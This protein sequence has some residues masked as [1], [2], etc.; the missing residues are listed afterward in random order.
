MKQHLLEKASWK[1]LPFVLITL[2][3]FSCSESRDSSLLVVYE[4]NHALAASINQ[5]MSDAT[6]QGLKTDT[7]SL[8]SDRRGD[9]LWKNKGVLLL[10]NTNHLTPQ[11]QTDIE[12]YV[13]TG[14]ALLAPRDTVNQYQWPWLFAAEEAG[15]QNYDGGRVTFFATATD[16]TGEA[17]SSSLAE[18]AINKEGAKS[19]AAPDV[20]RFTK[21]ILDAE[22]NEPMELDILPDGK[23]L[24][25]E[26]EGN[27]KMFD[28]ESNET[29]ILHTFKVNTE[30]N[31]EDGMLGLA[32]D[33]NYDQNNWIYIYYSPLG[34]ASRQN[35]SRFTLLAD[36]LI[37]GSEKIVLE[38]GVQRETCCHSGGGIV[39]GPNGHL[40][41]STGDNTSSKESSG[42]SP[43]DERPGRGPF[44]SQ[45][46][47]SNTHD[48]RGKILRIKPTA[49]GSYTI[50]DGNLFPKD[51]SQGRPEIYVMGCRN[52]FRFTVDMKT[53]YVYWGDV[54]PD[55]GRD[56]EKGP[57][58]Y[59]EWNQ[60]KT[61][62]FYGWP[63]FEANNIAFPMVDFATDEI[64]PKQDPA[65][66]INE[67]PNN[68]GSRE[69]PPARP[70]MIW[71]PYGQSDIWP[72]LGTGSRS[73][74]SGPMYY[75][76]ANASKAGFPEY[77]NGKLFIY[78]WA[79]SW[80]KVV[81][82]DEDWNPTQIESF[83]PDETFVKPIDMEFDKNG[84]MYLLEYGSN[85]F[86]NNVD[87]R[88]VRIEYAE[89]N[90]APVP[91]VATDKTRGAVPLT[92]NF[93]AQGSFDYDKDDAL[94]FSWTTKDGKKYE[95]R[96]VSITFDQPGE[97]EVE[98]TVTDSKGETASAFAR[99]IAGNEPSNIDF[100]YSG[101]QSFYFGKE[102]NTYKVIVT[103][104]EDGS[105]EDGSIT[106][107]AVSVNFS[108]LE[109]G[110][111][112]ANLGEDFFKNP[113]INVK[114]KNMIAN[115]DCMSCHSVDQ[116]S[117]GPTYI[118][119][120]KRYADDPSSRDMLA[121]K[122][123]EGGNG[124]WGHSL[125][126][127][128]PQLT[129]DETRVMVDYILSLVKESPTTS[130]PLTSNITLNKQTAENQGAYV[131]GIRYTDKGNGTIP[132]IESSKMIM[133]KAPVLEAEN[134]NFFN[135]VQQQR[136]NGG[137]FAFLSNINDG[138]YI[139]YKNIDLKGISKIS[140]TMMGVKGGTIKVVSGSPTG[141]VIG[142]VDVP[143]FEGS[144]RD[145]QWANAD[146][147]IDMVDQ[148]GNLYF[149]VSHPDKETNLMSLD[150]ISFFK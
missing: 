54:G 88:L 43:L 78:E 84:V 19:L 137:D 135:D 139:G 57:Q 144:W 37:V 96:D 33:P 58:S 129:L 143:A 103:D 100:D 17:I 83:L 147:T 38:V 97:Q 3:G 150:K 36:S 28:P 134:Y 47:S 35:L 51:G 10:A 49:E 60:A 77:Y 75:K 116:K 80:I 53:G 121:G 64:G 123:I 16:L 81:S 31:Y 114:G 68:T 93:S 106:Q 141:K 30:G 127:A 45:K 1:L 69:L 90:R 110:Y 23:L 86:A 12:R 125:M 95:G 128:H 92:V 74:M 119:I 25:I 112:Q 5:I 41:L 104:K 131:V 87:A 107:E 105:T 48:L 50:P 136:P 63:Y 148:I 29:K 111:D 94:I 133:I 145:R 27:L 142:T 70:A 102:T 40:Y 26:R 8:T 14:G 149:V 18:N 67:S 71:Y 9:N 20:S 82:F 108:Y 132:A 62:G 13:Q 24:F 99:V 124:N 52:P 115:S 73:A 120:A 22:V 44:D 65:H 59:D 91:A 130:L 118:E 2:I 39:F 55:S 117:I 79:R 11:W 126:A 140:V 46:G 109:G 32:V 101:N 15:T 146:I 85:Y 113:A 42:Y 56:S 21:I 6:T 98:L 72:M 122:I 7:V 76:P 34:G 66:P 138:S 61:P 89:G 4:K